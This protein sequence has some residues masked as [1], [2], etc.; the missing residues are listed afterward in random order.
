MAHECDVKE[1]S[2]QPTLAIRTRTPVGELSQVLG[3]AY[4]AI[5]QYVG[6]VGGQFAGPPYVAYYNDDM[7]DLDIE[8]GLPVAPQLP[9][10]DEIEAEEIPGGRVATCIHVGPYDEIE[11]AY[12]ALVH[13]VA[14]NG[15]ESTGVAYE[16]YLNDPAETPA[17]ELMTEIMFPLET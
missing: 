3:Q 11:S 7:E 12:E 6:E 5:A 13:W 10:K 9:G 14:E 4:G 1:Q 2:S 8:I 17:E 16:F 15:Y